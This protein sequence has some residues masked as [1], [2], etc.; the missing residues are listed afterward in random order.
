MKL[1]VFQRRLGWYWRLVAR[2]KKKRAIGGEP[3]SSASAAVRG[4]KSLH[5]D[6]CQSPPWR[7]ELEVEIV[8]KKKKKR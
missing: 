2:N 8:R 3:F 4:F 5:T 1:V 7:G 6:L